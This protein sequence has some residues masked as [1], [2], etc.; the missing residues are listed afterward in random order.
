M[1]KPKKIN[2]N[3]LTN[4]KYS[5]IN[6][7]NSIN[8]HI[9][10]LS[11]VGV[12]SRNNQYSL[13]LLSQESNIQIGFTFNNIDNLINFLLKVANNYIDTFDINSDLYPREKLE[14]IFDYLECQNIKTSTNIQ[15]NYAFSFEYSR[16]R[17]CKFKEIGL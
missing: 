1:S 9:E 4:T 14:S 7:L 15:F 5:S 12:Y 17:Y 8:K 3:T 6:Y 16:L 2:I 10:Y 13:Y 11:W